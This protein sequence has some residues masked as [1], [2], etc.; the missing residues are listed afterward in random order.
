MVRIGLY[1]TYPHGIGGTQ[2]VILNLAEHLP[3]YGYQPVII[4]PEAGVLTQA[5]RTAGLDVLISDPGAAWHVYGR[6]NRA[7]SYI[8]SPARLLHMPRYWHTLRADLRRNNIALLQC[9][10]LRDLIMA[11]PAAR[12]AGVPVVW[13]VHGLTS[14]PLLEAAAA[15]LAQRVVLVSHGMREYWQLPPW[16]VPPHRVIHNGLQMPSIDHNSINGT[17]A[18]PPQIV[19]VGV[20]HPRKGYETLLHAMQQV[21]RVLP[22]VQ[23]KIV[24][25]E[26]GDGSYAR[27]L[28]DLSRRLGV[29][30][31]VSFLGYQKD[32]ESI[33]HESTVMVI[34][35]QQ[36]TFGMV[37]L[38]A[39]TASKPVVANRTGGLAEIVAH[40]KTGFLVPPDRPDL[41]AAALITTL[42]HPT[43]AQQFG[44]QG[45]QRALTEFSA[46]R[47]AGSFA[48]LYRE[49]L[50]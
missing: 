16:L 26:W 23:C 27:D 17:P 6:G 39:M 11:A 1:Q 9:N 7:L 48:A 43:L 2:R 50:R 34:P 45:R 5:A 41:M 42:Q 21:A 40:G 3:A 8:T 37:A 15:R 36:E 28:H 24:G 14:L 33:L 29:D 30:N 18:C 13:H 22:Q 12:L 35:S 38:E 20:L 44:A 31:N 49:V 32:V 46:Q 19:A 25:G 4:C 10:G 47:M